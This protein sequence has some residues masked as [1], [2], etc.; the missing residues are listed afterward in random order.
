MFDTPEL[1]IYFPGK[2]VIRRG[3]PQL[4]HR[5]KICQ[6]NDNFAD[7]NE[8]GRIY[9]V[10]PQRLE[11]M[12]HKSAEDL[13]KITRISTEDIPAKSTDNASDKTKIDRMS[14]DGDAKLVGTSFL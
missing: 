2:K 9:G 11:M 1:G 4:L 13:L 14:I 5:A 10:S 7:S 8:I 3:S 6:S 12:K